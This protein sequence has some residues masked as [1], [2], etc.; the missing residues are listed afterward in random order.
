MLPQANRLKHR[1]EF[2]AV[3]QNGMRRQSSHLILRALG[4]PCAENGQGETAPA[5][6]PTRIG[7]VVG[8]KVSK[9]AVVRNRIKRRIRAG[10]RQFLPR[11]SPGW[12]LV[13]I[14]RPTAQECEYDEFLRELEQL[15]AGIE[16]LNGHSR[17]HLL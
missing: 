8:Q 12:Q 10:L 11:L 15:L 13:V 3:Y 9:R 4:N 16:V 1:Q 17:G 14:A 5:P 7:V 2:Q 6:F